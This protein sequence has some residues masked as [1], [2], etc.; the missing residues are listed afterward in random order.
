VRTYG[1]GSFAVDRASV[2]PLPDDPHDTW[3]AIDFETAT[4]SRDSA[5]ALGIAV[6]R[7]GRVTSTAA[8]LIRPPGNRYSRW[9]IA[10]HGITPE[11][12]RA[13]PS[14]NELY[15][16]VEPFL[17]DGRVLAHSAPFDVS[18]LRALGELYGLARPNA[19]YACSCMLSRRA[20]PDLPDHRLPTV[21]DHCG[22][23]LRHHDAASDAIACAHVA[24]SC[25]DAAGAATISEAVRVLGASM[26]VL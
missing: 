15:P 13:A 10:I 17:R 1:R 12:T 3:V 26:S 20:F 18:V 8:W 16:E 9:N 14:W 25:R 11:M 21:C 5:C 4:G 6:I 24:L 22:I 19:R 7:D 23:S 2:A